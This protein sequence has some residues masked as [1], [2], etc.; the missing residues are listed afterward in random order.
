MNLLLAGIFGDTMSTMK[1]ILAMCIVLGVIYLLVTIPALRPI[2]ATVFAVVFV[3]MG[4][5]AT[6]QNIVYLST[7]SMT[8]GQVINSY[9]ETKQDVETIEQNNGKPIWNLKNFGFK[10]I[11]GNIYESTIILDPS[12]ELDLANNTYALFVNNEL[13]L[14]TEIGTDYVK[15]KYNYT[16][17]DDIGNIILTDTLH[18]NFA[19]NTN[20]TKLVLRTTN[21]LSAA[22]LWKSYQA[23]NN[24]LLELKTSD[25]KTPEFG[26]FDIITGPSVRYEVIE[27]NSLINKTKINF[28][29]GKPFYEKLLFE[30]NKEPR[31]SINENGEFV[32]YECMALDLYYD[33]ARLYSSTCKNYEDSKNFNTANFLETQTD[34]YYISFSDEF[35]TCNLLSDRQLLINGSVNGSDKFIYYFSQGILKFSFKVAFTAINDALEYWDKDIYEYNEMELGTT[36][37]ETTLDISNLLETDLTNKEINIYFE[38]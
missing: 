29:M 22:N 12:T 24:M 33:M 21:G 3:F 2:L 15:S 35:Y 9:M 18:I 37:L 5:S 36:L 32:E 11:D 23:K 19:F 16:F 7:N 8:V 1:V 10:N 28:H 31:G 30:W 14:Q 20:E 25:Y 13:C 38:Y 34:E 27:N 26:N 17:Y 6:Y 4:V